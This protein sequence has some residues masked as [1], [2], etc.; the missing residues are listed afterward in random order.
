[1]KSRSEMQDT[2]VKSRFHD[3]LKIFFFGPKPASAVT[4]SMAPS[5]RGGGAAAVRAGW[6]RL[7]SGGFAAGAGGC[8]GARW[9]R[10]DAS[11][12]CARLGSAGK[13]AQGLKALSACGEREVSQVGGDSLIFGRHIFY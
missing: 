9:P 11:A 2:V 8:P 1:M 13:S 12:A 5:S 6:R 7:P 10:V 4:R 3:F